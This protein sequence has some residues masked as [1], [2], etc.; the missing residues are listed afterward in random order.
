MFSPLRMFRSPLFVATAASTIK[1]RDVENRLAYLRGETQSAGE[2][3]PDVKRC[4]WPATR[5]QLR[6]RGEALDTQ[7]A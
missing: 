5:V 3:S 7:V 4:C 2:Q 1:T 6:I